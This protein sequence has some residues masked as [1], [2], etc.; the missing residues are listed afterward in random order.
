VEERTLLNGANKQTAE[1]IEDVRGPPCPFLKG[2][3][4]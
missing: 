4:I 3:R 1:A 2:Q